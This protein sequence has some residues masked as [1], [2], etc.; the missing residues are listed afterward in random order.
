M[1]R[2]LFKNVIIPLTVVA[3]LVSCTREKACNFEVENKYGDWTILA[4]LDDYNEKIFLRFDTK[5]EGASTPFNFYFSF[6]YSNK[7][8]EQEII[9][10]QNDMVMQF[11]YRL[12][13][14]TEIQFDEN[15]Y[16]S[17]STSTKINVWYTYADKDIKD[18]INARQFNVHF[19]AGWYVP[20]KNAK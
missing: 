15:G 9:T 8:G 11:V 10:N 13:D 19:G 4:T 1:K 12:S 20:D 2:S 17:F 14:G 5:E 6:S 3:S 18:A 7:K 16:Y